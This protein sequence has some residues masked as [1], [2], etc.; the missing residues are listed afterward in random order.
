MIYYVIFIMLFCNSLILDN[1]KIKQSYS[2]NII[3]IFLCLLLF[4]VVAVRYN[5]G[6]D[7]VPYYNIFHTIKNSSKNI[8]E[9]SS[10]LNLEIGYVFLNIVL[11]KLNFKFFFFIIAALTVL[12]KCFFI[13]KIRKNRFLVLF[14]YYCTVF[15]TY[16]MGIIRQGISL[17][18]LLFSIK[19]LLNKNY[20]KFQLIVIFA[21]L[22]HA[23]SIIFSVAFFVSYKEYNYKT[24]LIICF[25]SLL[26]S[27]FINT[28]NV[29]S[30]IPN[31][32]G[33]I[34]TKISYYSNYYE[35]SSIFISLIKRIIVMLIFLYCCKI[36]KNKFDKL[37]WFSLNAYMLSIVLMSI[38][39]GVA[40][41][42]SRGTMSLYMFQIV[43]Y[44][45]VV[46]NKKIIEYILLIILCFSLFFSSF[47]GPLKDKY[48][49]YLPYETWID[50]V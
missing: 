41:L 45:Y 44:S 18:I 7:Y 24:Y 16:D 35:E 25:I 33:I 12:P 39:N 9:L 20:I 32:G 50:D 4:F 40:M 26:F 29:L 38:F 43:C 8:F 15:L 10:N 21:S 46:N 23:T 31:S 5:T 49:F 6:Y 42:A 13:S 19:Y 30:I 48:N 14:C 3:Y 22:F 17:S 11:S 47:V 37:F 27:L 28:S 36:E 1:F 2:K 34:D